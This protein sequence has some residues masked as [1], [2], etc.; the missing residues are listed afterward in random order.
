MRSDHDLKQDVLSE[1][2]WDPSVDGTHIAVTIDGGGVVRLT[3]HASTYGERHAAEQAALR[4][5][6]VRAVT[7]ELDVRLKPGATW[8]DENVAAECM[9]SLHAHTAVPVSRIKLIVMNGWVT[10]EGTVDWQFQKAAAEKALRYL[11][12]IRG[13]TNAIT[14]SP[15]AST[16]GVKEKIEAALRRNAQIDAQRITVETRDGRVI[17]R[18]QVRS[19]TEL[20]HAQKAAWAAPGV[21]AVDNDL[22]VVS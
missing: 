4:V 8:S 7:N 19:W 6:G 22:V 5:H 14:V 12:G 3:G 18:G 11:H 10:L 20:R 13:I 1:L 21:T 2:D 9:T 17:L 15:N 16:L